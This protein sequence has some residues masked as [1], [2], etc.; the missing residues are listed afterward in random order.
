MAFAGAWTARTAAKGS[1]RIEPGW[2]A[3][4]E[5]EL[6]NLLLQIPPQIISY[7]FSR[8]WEVRYLKI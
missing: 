1:G 3:T 4:A 5:W 2:R 8:I 7:F 6:A